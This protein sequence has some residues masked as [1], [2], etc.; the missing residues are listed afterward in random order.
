MKQEAERVLSK[1]YQE[2]QN[3]DNQ[4]ERVR[5]RIQGEQNTRRNLEHAFDSP[6]RPS[7][8]AKAGPSPTKIPVQSEIASGSGDKPAFKTNPESDHEPKGPRGRPRKNPLPVG[9][10]AQPKAKAKAQ[11]K[12]I[13]KAE[14]QPTAQ[15]PSGSAPP[16][17]QP[18]P[19]PKPQPKPPPKP[20]PKP[21]KPTAPPKAK[22]EP[23]PKPPPVK[24]DP[25]TK[26]KHGTVIDPSVDPEYWKDKALGYI[27]D[28]LGLRGFKQ[29]KFPD[30]RNLKKSDYL[31]E[32]L[33]RL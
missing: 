8:K 21:P 31:K 3:M 13:P 12:W 28:Q 29:H 24:K 4:D 16:K 1:E 9:D 27:K 6:D 15:R 26:P 17:P 18:K 22:A 33:S 20:Q 5:A 14:P 23:K 11:P 30:G 19:P 25:I 2:R 10:E 7:A 32:M